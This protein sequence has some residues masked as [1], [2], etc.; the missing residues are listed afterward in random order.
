MRTWIA[1]MGLL[2]VPGLASGVR[3]DWVTV[4]ALGYLARRR[5]GSRRK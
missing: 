5:K 1:I 3:I 2:G 4:G